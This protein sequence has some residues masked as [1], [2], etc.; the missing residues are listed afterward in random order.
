MALYKIDFN[1][2]WKKGHSHPKGS[3]NKYAH[4]QCELHHPQQKSNN[5]KF[6]RSYIRDCHE[7]STS[8]LQPYLPHQ[9]PHDNKNTLGYSNES[10]FE[11]KQ[12][13]RQD[14][15]SIGCNKHNHSK[16]GE[17]G[18]ESVNPITNYGGIPPGFGPLGFEPQHCES[19]TLADSSSKKRKLDDDKKNEIGEES[20][21]D[22][23]GHLAI[24][25][26]H[27]NHQQVDSNFEN[28]ESS[29]TKFE[30]LKES[31]MHCK[32]FQDS[33]NKALEENAT[34][35]QQI[36]TLNKDHLKMKEDKAKNLRSLFILIKENC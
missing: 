7:S 34:L 8:Q 6:Q 35:K 3:I 5:Y 2:H 18:L 22:C 32:T 23:E 16:V 15:F 19:K 31:C 17:Y 25:Q 4:N 29:Q 26:I 24:N 20:E 10:K 36:N 33:L 21:H 1:R 13:I 12:D 28:K 14:K 11:M 30:V 9:Q 27:V